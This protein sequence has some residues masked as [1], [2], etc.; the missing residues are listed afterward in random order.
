MLAGYLVDHPYRY[1]LPEQLQ[2]CVAASFSFALC[3]PDGEENKGCTLVLADY[4]DHFLF[5]PAAHLFS[6]PA[7]KSGSHPASLHY[8]DSVRET[9]YTT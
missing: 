9:A 4:H 1:C 6:S 2:P 8:F 3:I 7:D 5:I